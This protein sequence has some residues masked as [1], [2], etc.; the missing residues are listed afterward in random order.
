MTEEDLTLP[1][2]PLKDLVMRYKDE[3]TS[4]LFLLSAQIE[5]I[6]DEMAVAWIIVVYEGSEDGVKC[7]ESGVN[8]TV[9]I[10]TDLLLAIRPLCFTSEPLFLANTLLGLE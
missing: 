1:Y 4:R 10:T 3:A 2:Q 5:V 9:S 8:M 7:C 6:P